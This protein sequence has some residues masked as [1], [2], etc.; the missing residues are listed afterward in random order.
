MDPLDGNGSP[1]VFSFF[2]MLNPIPKSNM[3]GERE[4][5]KM[6]NMGIEW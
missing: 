3:L 2:L 6:G 1:H 4:Y 5:L